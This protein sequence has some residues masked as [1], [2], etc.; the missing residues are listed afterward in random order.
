MRRLYSIVRDLH[1][2]SGLFISP[3]VLV[4]AVSV[5]FLVHAWIPGSSAAPAKR[6]AGDLPIPAG[7]ELLTGRAQV[8][9]LR[10][11]LDRLGVKG[12]VGV[13]RR[14]A[15]EHRLVIAVIIPG[16]EVSV[17]LN[18]ETRSAEVTERATGIGSAITYLHKMP[19]QHL[20]N[21]R[22]NWG[23]MRFWRWLADGTVYVV[24]FLTLSGVYLWAVLRAE[25]RVGLA[26]IAAG[27]FSFFGS[28]YALV[29]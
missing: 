12:E 20:A 2:Y 5:F 15:K 8:A 18:L 6:T 19:G 26:L 3:L 27:A 25:R 10:G 23:Y 28:L 9:A 21:L 29:H 1:L 4:F 14:I 11:V 7:V 13:L 24:M 16:R 22:G 17:D